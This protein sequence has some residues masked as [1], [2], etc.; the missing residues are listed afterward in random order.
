MSA[1]IHT[2]VAAAKKPSVVTPQRFA[3]GLTW[4]QYQEAMK[5]NK[6]R[7]LEEYNSLQVS[8]A[9]AGA[10][11]GLVKGAKGPINVLAIAEDWCPDVWRGLPVMV[12]IAEAA[13]MELRIFP[14]DQNLDIMSEFLYK[15]EF[16]SIPTF[17]FYT[18]DHKY[19]G[20][21]IERPDL[22]N[23]EMARVEEEVKREM[24]GKTD[25]E[26]R[27]ER[28]R[29]LRVHWPAW[30]QETVKEIREFL[31]QAVKS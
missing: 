22:A 30:K 15:G 3:Q 17:V 12:R 19:I 6:D 5:V 2:S 26:I 7:F 23:R 18:R 4:A 28:G 27:A 21:W 16:Q 20:H 13:G 9:D 31:S 1:H 14:R 10:L 24:P 8:K 11:K 29:R 25:Q